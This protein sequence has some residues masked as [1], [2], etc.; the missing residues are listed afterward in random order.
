MIRKAAISGLIIL[1]A[2]MAA[3]CAEDGAGPK[4]KAPTVSILKPAAGS[5]RA[6]IVDIEVEAT[7]D[8]GIDCVELY[9]GNLLR[10]TDR[11]K[12]YI[13]KLD[14]DTVEGSVSFYV[15]A[16][17]IGDNA[18]MSNTVTITKGGTAPEILTCAL[19]V[20]EV[21]QGYPVVMS[22]TATDAQDGDL[23]DAYITWSSSLQGPLREGKSVEYRGLVI[24]THIITLTA[25]DSNGNTK[26]QTVNLTVTE[27][28]QN[29]AYIQEGSYTIGP[30]LFPERT[31]W[32]ERP[33]IISKTELTMGEF[34]D[35]INDT[36]FS[37]HF[38]EKSTVVKDLDKRMGKLEKPDETLYYPED[39]LTDADK[40]R[41]YPACFIAVSEFIEYC[42]A[43]SEVDGLTPAYKFLDKNNLGIDDEYYT[44][45]PSKWKP[46]VWTKAIAL[47]KSMDG[48]NGWRLPTEAEWEIAAS[49]G[50]A[51]IR[52]T[53][54]NEVPGSRCNCLSDPNP[55]NIIVLANG[56][57]IC[58]V[59]SYL[60]N[61]FGL[62]D[63]A[64]NVAEI[65][66][67]ISTANNPPYMAILPSGFDPL[68]TSE[69]RE[70]NHVVKGGAW[71]GRGEEMQIAIR[72]FWIPF[73]VKSTKKD[74]FN[75]GYGV[76]LVRNLEVGEAPW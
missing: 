66:S 27:N 40:Y 22:G 28:D 15:I 75:S 76:R 36:N 45:D 43:L 41:E 38:H 4:D 63:M 5:T 3:S 2:L 13:F 29:F 34:L 44:S 37:G 32:F 16:I 1:I 53:W 25:T 68:S 14:M 57:G 52:Y 58:P 9:V 70:V 21:M 59:K 65:C 35:N 42:Q 12:P 23:G 49:G 50:N 74:S 39:L 8:K 67:D 18:K 46:T 30:P 56:R 19:D 55:P 20:T 51:G 54:G 48:A 64:G 6:G 69:S 24:G 10:E 71:Y 11:I 17:D 33:F 26:K 60:P 47:N 31:I 7:D 62:F 73:D 72:Q 61:R